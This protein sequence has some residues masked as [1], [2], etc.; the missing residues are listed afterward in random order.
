MI[1]D[2]LF[3]TS[4][5]AVMR[6][7]PSPDAAVIVYNSRTFDVPAR[8]PRPT[9]ASSVARRSEVVRAP[10]SPPHAP[11]PHHHST[12]QHRP[13]MTHHVKHLHLP[14]RSR[15]STVTNPSHKSPSR[16]V[17]RPHRSPAS[18]RVRSRDRTIRARPGCGC[19]GVSRAARG[20][21]GRC[22]S[23]V[24]SRRRRARHGASRF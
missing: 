19:A 17:Y 7:H 10:P 8:T 6:S 21:R 20:G 24:A 15:H 12:H 22:Q 18:P 2:R 11:I 16:C 9:D 23:S 14:L 13:I 4:P 5:D 3:K 1:T